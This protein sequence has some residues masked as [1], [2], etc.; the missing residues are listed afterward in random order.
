MI[1]KK[2]QSQSTK[3]VESPKEEE[4]KVTRRQT[5]KRTSK[6]ESTE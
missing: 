6:K 2:L 3:I 1:Q 4:P 5:S